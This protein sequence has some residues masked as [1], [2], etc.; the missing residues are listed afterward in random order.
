M[1]VSDRAIIPQRRIAIIAGFGLF[2]LVT[3]A[4]TSAADMPR[5]DVEAHCKQIASFGGSYSAVLD[6]AC[7]DQEQQAYDRLKPVF[8]Q[9]TDAMSAHCEQI[10]S[11]GGPGSYTLLEACIS[12]E[13]QAAG[14]KAGKTFKY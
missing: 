11:F 9:L 10:A 1:Q 12:Q 5:F 3:S 14:D 6:K 4:P 2:S 7:F 13:I 8:G